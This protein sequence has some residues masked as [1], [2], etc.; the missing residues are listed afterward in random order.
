MLNSPP[1]LSAEWS[2][3]TVQMFRYVNCK[4]SGKANSDIGW[5]MSIDA[6]MQAGGEYSDN[7]ACN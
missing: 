1:S 4:L 7:V 2:K 3:K 5:N 6:Y